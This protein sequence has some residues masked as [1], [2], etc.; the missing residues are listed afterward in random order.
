M[1]VKFMSL[2]S[3]WLWRTGSE[4]ALLLQQIWVSAIISVMK[5]F[6][7]VKYCLVEPAASVFRVE[8]GGK[9]FL[10]TADKFLPM[11]KLVQIPEDFII[12][13]VRNL[14]FHNIVYNCW[15]VPKSC[16]FFMC[17]HF[18]SWW[19]WWWWLWWP[20][21]WWWWCWHEYGSY[22]TNIPVHKYL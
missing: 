7:A 20:R 22:E 10:Q 6:F 8:G 13:V 9:M 21:L 18:L 17:L 5:A 11:C 14:E 19:W 2:H 16:I 15:N 3:D 1:H 12:I 4:I